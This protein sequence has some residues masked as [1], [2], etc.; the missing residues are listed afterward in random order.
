MRLILA[1]ALIAAGLWATASARAINSGTRA[2]LHSS[3]LCD[4][5]VKQHS[6]Y[7]DVGHGRDL[8]FWFFERTTANPV[9]TESWAEQTTSASASPP[10]TLWLNG[11]PGCS[12]MYGLFK[13]LGPCAIDRTT[14]ATQLNP[15]SWHRASHLLFVDQPVGAGLSRTD[16][17][18]TES[19][20]NSSSAAAQDLLQFFYGFYEAFPQYRD[21]DLH[22]FGESYAGKYIPALATHIVRANLAL[23][24]AT[25]DT[26]VHHHINL[27]SIGI[28]NGWTNPL[29]QY[30]ATT[31]AICPLS[32]L[33]AEVCQK[34]EEAVPHCTAL[35]TACYAGKNLTTCQEA[36]DYCEDKIRGPYM[37]TSRSVYD[38]SKVLPG[39]GQEEIEDPHL[40]AF[41]SHPDVRHAIGSRISTFQSC[42]LEMTGAFIESGDHGANASPY[43]EYLLS[44]KVDTLLYVGER[45]VVCAWAGIE[46]TALALR[47]S[48]ATKFRT[49]ATHPLTMN[50]QT[51]GF[52]RRQGP[53]TLVRML[54]SGHMVPVDQPEAALHMFTHWLE[55]RLAN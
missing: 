17:Q 3:T 23:K 36:T 4:P 19:P 6:G 50:A 16:S 22:I 32:F 51:N 44:Q 7:I 15:W 1:P 5:S 25:T 34:T 24:S 29:L 53:L 11:G 49:A 30:A 10:L 39:P 8:F 43:L 14:N 20:M 27:Q 38:Y 13:E 26:S 31:K 9:Y 18:A 40:T 52:V 37:N 48:G 41:L 21:L 35:L 55:N 12:S 47:W 45:D 42:H 28:G 2:T 46:D 54:D 33:P